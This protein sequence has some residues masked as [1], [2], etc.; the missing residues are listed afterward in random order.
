MGIVSGEA[1]LYLEYMQKA[2]G[3]VLVMLGLYD[4]VM[5]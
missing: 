1:S 4:A 3:M 5:Q 2:E